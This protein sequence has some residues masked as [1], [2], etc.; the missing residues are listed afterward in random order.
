LAWGE[1][2]RAFRS[3]IVATLDPRRRLK[4]DAVRRAL[5]ATGCPTS[6]APMAENKVYLSIE[7]PGGQIC[8]DIFLR[9]DGTWGF[10]EY[11]RDPED[12]RGWYDTN[13]FGEEQFQSRNEAE[14]R[15]RALCPWIESP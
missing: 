4:P 11:R 3:G 9:P 13:R 10:T 8:V 6:G 12:G 7:A 15:A 1:L 14:T 5:T 2:S